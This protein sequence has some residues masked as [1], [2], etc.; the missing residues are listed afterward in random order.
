M[1]FNKVKT[2]Y[3]RPRASIIPN[4]EKLQSFPVKSEMK[5]GCP[6]SPFFFNIVLEFLARAIR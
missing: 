5:E 3:D 1:H 4:G 6:F 2:K